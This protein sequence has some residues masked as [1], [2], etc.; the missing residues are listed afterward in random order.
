LYVAP[1][2]M[3]SVQRQTHIPAMSASPMPAHIFQSL[4]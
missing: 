2:D 4:V 3:L 1:K